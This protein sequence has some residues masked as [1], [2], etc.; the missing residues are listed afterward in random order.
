MKQGKKKETIKFSLYDLQQLG[1]LGYGASAQVYL[2]KHKEKNKYLALK[3][4]PFKNEQKLKNLVETEV[5]L[6]SECHCEYIIRCYASYYKEGSVNMVIE[7][8]N[9]GTLADILKKV[10]KIPENILGIITNQI[11]HGLYYLQK[12]KLVVH[13][14][15]KPSNILLNSNGYAKISDFGISKILEDSKDNLKTLIG[16][17]IYMSPERIRG[18]NYGFNSDIWSVSMAVLEC[19]TGHHPY[20]QMNGFENVND[21]WSLLYLIDSNTSPCLNRDEFSEEFCDFIEVSLNKD[22]KSRLNASN[23]LNH[24]FVVKYENQHADFAKWLSQIN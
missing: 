2:L 14:D 4:I 3:V 18:E 7:Y 24:P 15:I 1:L 13:R 22:P 20:Q 6:L 8:M 12:E 17:Y 5:K 19:A 11:L 10:K 16:T 23:L 21:L 9:K